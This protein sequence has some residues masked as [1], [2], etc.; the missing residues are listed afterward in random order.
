M[1][2]LNVFLAPGW[3]FV[4]HHSQI[5]ISIMAGLLTATY[6]SPK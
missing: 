5:I 3:N 1:D 2:A 4:F 6:V